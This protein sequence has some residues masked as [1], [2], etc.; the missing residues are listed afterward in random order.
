MPSQTAETS[1][2]LQAV[3]ALKGFDRRR[4]VMLIREELAAGAPS[5]ERWRSVARLA[6][7]LG[8]IDLEIEATRRYAQSQ[9]QTLD[10]VLTYGKLL[11]RNGRDAEAIALTD[12]LP[13]SA[14]AHPSVLHFRG[15][16]ATQL[17]RF[18]EAENFFR[19]ALAISPFAAQTIRMSPPS[20]SNCAVGGS[21]GVATP[22][23]GSK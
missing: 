22:W 21:A 18:D 15:M 1:R 8:E 6:G 2:I 12:G 13:D 9:P 17:G 23:F 11:A 14:Q 10:H 19:K 3:E 20:V 5:G 16:I 7:T 4:A